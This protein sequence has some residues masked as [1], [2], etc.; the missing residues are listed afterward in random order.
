M[1]L[2]TFTIWKY[3]VKSKS[4]TRNLN[5]R[6]ENQGARDFIILNSF[7]VHLL[8]KIAPSKFVENIRAHVIYVLKID[9]FIKIAPQKF[10]FKISGV[11]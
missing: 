9:L 2:E 3:V 4:P 1:E 10:R 6:L 11:T 5:F 7:K 8:I